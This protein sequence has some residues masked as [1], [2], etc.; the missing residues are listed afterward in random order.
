[1]PYNPPY[2]APAPG[3]GD[4]SSFLQPDVLEWVK[5]VADPPAPRWVQLY[6]ELWGKPNG[7]LVCGI[8]C[9]ASSFDLS[10]DE[11]EDWPIFVRED[12]VAAYEACRTEAKDWM[13]RMVL[14]Y[15]QPGIGKSLFLRYCAVRACEDK[16]PFIFA[17]AGE[18]Y[19]IVFCGNRPFA[20]NLRYLGRRLFK[21][22][23][24]CFILAD[25]AGADPVS[26]RLTSRAIKGLLIVAT[27]PD[28]A[29][30]SEALKARP[31]YEFFTFRPFL[32]FEFLQL[33]TLLARSSSGEAP[34]S[35][36]LA[37]IRPSAAGEA[38]PEREMADPN[39]PLFS[40]A[41]VDADE[42]SSR[43]PPD[44]EA[45]FASPAWGHECFTPLELY[46]AL[47]PTVR[48][49]LSKPSRSVGLLDV[50]GT[51]GVPAPTSVIDAMLNPLRGE[52]AQLTGFFAF[53]H[54]YP[55]PSAELALSPRPDVGLSVPTPFLR[56]RIAE[57]IARL[58]AQKRV[59]HMQGLAALGAY[60]VLHELYYAPFVLQ[61][62]AGAPSPTDVTLASGGT[63][64]LP[65]EL[66]LFSLPPLRDGTSLPLLPGVYALP[67]GFPSFTAFVVIC[68]QPSL[69]HPSPPASQLIAVQIALVAGCGVHQRAL[70]R[71]NA[72]LAA[73]PTLRDHKVEKYLLFISPSADVAQAAAEDADNTTLSSA[74]GYKTVWLHLS[75]EALARRVGVEPFRYSAPIP[76]MSI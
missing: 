45:F 58:G 11:E 9:L 6:D 55:L 70:E 76:E 56:E 38:R 19:V 7:A 21:F 68:P 16:L 35:V 54:L 28:R 43:L 53:F 8:G 26:P 13:P 5:A 46:D 72:A 60:P 18:E 30:Y 31:A 41:I 14:A 67:A 10:R 29:H 32:R 50:L 2:S 27:S 75:H 48:L 36:A 22:K 1:M 37:Q 24:P 33:L 20:L 40:D 64:S 66:P 42:P 52:W 23:G 39:D 25:T 57:D 62:L 61:H 71:V 74:L 34:T 65:P 69:L 17:P 63:L 44:I 47:G 51:Y 49:A 12:Y 73:S 4:A 15:G 59:E 3:E